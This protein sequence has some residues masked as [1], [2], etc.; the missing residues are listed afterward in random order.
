MEKLGF[1]LK[2]KRCINSLS[3]L[4]KES[5]KSMSRNTI[6]TFQEIAILGRIIKIIGKC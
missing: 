6:Y 1:D 2:T 5:N 3:R 4:T